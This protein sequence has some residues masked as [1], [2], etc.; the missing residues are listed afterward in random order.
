[1]NVISSAVRCP[2]ARRVTLIAVEI[3]SGIARKN[4]TLSQLPQK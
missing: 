4:G 2:S 1:M 3:V